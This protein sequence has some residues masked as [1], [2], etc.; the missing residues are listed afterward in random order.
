MMGSMILTAT[1]TANERIVP[2]LAELVRLCLAKIA[3]DQKH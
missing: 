1:A 3:L 2:L